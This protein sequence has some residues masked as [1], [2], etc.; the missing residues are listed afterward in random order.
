MLAW[1]YLAI[2]ASSC[3]FRT[4]KSHADPGASMGWSLLP[5]GLEA[6]IMPKHKRCIYGCFKSNESILCIYATAQSLYNC[7]HALKI[8]L[9]TRPALLSY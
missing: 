8:L 5:Q 9:M 3:P 2:S 6:S 7:I 1:K 4:C